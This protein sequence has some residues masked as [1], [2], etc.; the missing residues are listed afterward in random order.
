M[1]QTTSP[2]ITAPVY[3]LMFSLAFLLGAQQ[4]AANETGLPEEAGNINTGSGGNPV[5]VIFVNGETGN[6]R[7]V[8]FV[9]QGTPLKITAI[10]PPAGPSSAAFSLYA[11]VGEPEPG[12]LRSL[13]VNTGTMV[14][15]NP[16]TDPGGNTFVLANNF[17]IPQLGTPL[18]P[19]GPAPVTILNRPLGSPRPV[20]LTLQGIMRDF[21]APNGRAGVT[22]AIILKILPPAGEIIA[23]ERLQNRDVVIRDLTT[24]IETTIDPGGPSRSMSPQIDGQGKRVVFSSNLSGSF[25]I[26]LHDIATQTTTPLSTGGTDR[27]IPDI[28]ADGSLVVFEAGSP[29][30]GREIRIHNLRTNITR[31]LIKEGIT[32]FDPFLS[33]DGNFVA[34]AAIEG[35]ENDIY[36]YDCRLDELT[37]ASPGPAGTDDSPSVSFNGK[38]VAFR[39]FRDGPSQIFVYTRAT[40]SVMNVSQGGMGISD[41]QPEVSPDGRFVAFRTNRDGDREIYLVNLQSLQLTNISTS[42]GSNDEK[43]SFNSDGTSIFYASDRTG[44]GDIYRYDLATQMTT[45]V[46]F[47]TDTDGTPASN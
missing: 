19:A 22:N 38:K 47:S 6:E 16:V 46:T 43:P 9:T 31:K 15:S 1:V 23:F 34:A 36:L 30:G 40:Q 14:L 37:L 42:P 3:I 4:V 41:S 12:Q 2:R 21:G 17:G 33:P 11:R 28:S 5:P 8:V 10:A 18:L 27:I 29:S 25:G 13:P 7:N 39:S 20:T 45:Q 32:L 35:L 26:Y 24:G 44:N